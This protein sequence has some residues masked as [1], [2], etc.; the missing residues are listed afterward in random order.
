MQY[1]IIIIY[2]STYIYLVY[3]IPNDGIR[4]FY[5]RPKGGQ[6]K[7]TAIVAYVLWCM[8]CLTSLLETVHRNPQRERLP[9]YDNNDVIIS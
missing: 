5:L 9:F 4:Q 1:Y 8:L 3:I 7:Q 2:I 6:L